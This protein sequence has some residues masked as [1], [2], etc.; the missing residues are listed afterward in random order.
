[1]PPQAEIKSFLEILLG[2]LDDFTLKI[3][4]V[5]AIVSIGVSVGTNWGTDHAATSW[6]E[7]FAIIVAIMI[8]ALVTSINDYQKEKQFLD[9]NNKANSRK[10][11]NVIRNGQSTILH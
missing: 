1:M 9:L 6:I 4:M 3:L 8:C 5:S 7:G 11:I 2:A 10:T